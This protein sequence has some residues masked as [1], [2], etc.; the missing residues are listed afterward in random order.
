MARVW[1]GRERI[2]MRVQDV[3]SRVVLSLMLGTMRYLK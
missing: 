1:H 2:E 3:K